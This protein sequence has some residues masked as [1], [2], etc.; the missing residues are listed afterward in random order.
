MSIHELE[1][2]TICTLSPTEL[3]PDE[4]DYRYLT[5]GE[6]GIMKHR[7]LLEMTVGPEQTEKIIM[8]IAK[9]SKMVQ[10]DEDKNV[11]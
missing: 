5:P 1:T 9:K 3:R 10:T 7:K 2:T 11:T 4:P 6:M 8:E